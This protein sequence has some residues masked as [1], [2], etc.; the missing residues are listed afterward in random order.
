MLQQGLQFG[1]AESY[2]RL[3]AVGEGSYATVY[4]GFSHLMNKVVALKEIRLEADE[5]TPFTAIREGISLSL[6]PSSTLSP[7]FLAHHVDTNATASLLRS[8]N[9][10]N[11]IKLHDVVHTR[12]TLTFVFEFVVSV[13]TV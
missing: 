8:L 4:K 7:D 12:T 1:Q 13:V 2:V 3:D 11:I 9:H 6:R 10:I 5:G